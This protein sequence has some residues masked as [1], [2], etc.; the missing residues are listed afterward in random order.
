M[1]N[2]KLR[3]LS[4]PFAQPTLQIALWLLEVPTNSF[5]EGVANIDLGR[6]NPW[7]SGRREEGVAGFTSQEKC[8]I[9]TTCVLV[10]WGSFCPVRQ[11]PLV[12]GRVID[13][14][15]EAWRQ[16][17][18]WGNHFH[19]SIFEVFLFSFIY[20]QCLKRSL[21]T[22]KYSPICKINSDKSLC[23]R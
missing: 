10:R 8:L 14:Q 15:H 3:N 21:M 11:I 2:W 5:R 16:Q 9:S 20:C 1:Q 4:K 12:D 13:F 19:F 22:R 7:W 18:Q 6:R 17:L 23:L